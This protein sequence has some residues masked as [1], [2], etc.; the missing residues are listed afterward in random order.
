MDAATGNVLNEVSKELGLNWNYSEVYK[1]VVFTRRVR[2]KAGSAI[3][4]LHMFARTE[5]D[6]VSR[7]LYSVRQMAKDGSL[8]KHIHSQFF[9]ESL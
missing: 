7:P 1:S 6:I 3:E 8:K 5:S 9:R 4:L 2:V